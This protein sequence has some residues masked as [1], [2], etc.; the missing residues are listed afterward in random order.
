MP[1]DNDI[2]MHMTND[3]TTF[4]FFSQIYGGKDERWRDLKKDFQV[5]F[6]FNVKIYFKHLKI[7]FKHDL[8]VPFTVYSE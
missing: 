2:S 1:S 6:F 7:C 5:F 4:I 8:S 3:K